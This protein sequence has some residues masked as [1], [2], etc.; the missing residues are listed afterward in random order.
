MGMKYEPLVTESLAKQ[1]SETIRLAILEGELKVDERLPT[2]P[3]LAARFGVSRPTIREAL[4][5][6]AAQNLIRSRR[7]PTGGTFINRPDSDEA[8]NSLTNITSLLTTMGEFDLSDIAEARRE[9][10]LVCV[11]LAAERREES[12]LERLRA[13]I[14]IQKTPNLADQDFCA[15]DV[16]FHRTLVDA[17][18]NAMLRFMMSSVIEAVQPIVNLIVF[19]FWDKE[20]TIAQHERMLKAIEDQDAESA[21]MV[22]LEQMDDLQNRY[23]K[24]QALRDAK[25]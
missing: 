18:Q 2:E 12:H 4:K 20:K 19:K 9:L 23:A 3:E 21:A 15:S 25:T 10:E 14:H 11:R 8:Q 22:F 6:L 13:E 24:A 7:G 5:R 17:T 1:I 16:R